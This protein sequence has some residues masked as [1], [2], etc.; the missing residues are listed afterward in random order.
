MRISIEKKWLDIPN[1]TS[2][3]VLFKTRDE[4]VRTSQII[5]LPSNKET[6]F[7]AKMMLLTIFGVMSRQRHTL[8]LQYILGESKPHFD[9]RDSCNKDF[10]EMMEYTYKYV[11][12]GG[13]ESQAARLFEMFDLMFMQ[14]HEYYHQFDSM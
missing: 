9:R 1:T 7:Y 10:Q 12:S 2:M 11:Q 5:C 8:N 13:D 6:H 3:Q 4:V 14:V